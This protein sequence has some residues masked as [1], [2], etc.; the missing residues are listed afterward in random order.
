MQF[1]HDES[2][3]K[4]N[5]PSQKYQDDSKLQYHASS[6]SSYNSELPQLRTRIHQ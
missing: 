3:L 1:Y 5:I 6:P 2:E 4:A